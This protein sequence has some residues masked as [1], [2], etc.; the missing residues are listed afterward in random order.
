M[1]E[2]G[3]ITRDRAAREIN[4][5]KFTKNAQKGKRE[6]ELLLEMRRPLLELQ[7]LDQASTKPL[8]AD[9]PESPADKKKNGR[10]A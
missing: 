5:T 8:P 7:A 3:F 4:G 9:A 1:V 10:A 2:Q 6:S